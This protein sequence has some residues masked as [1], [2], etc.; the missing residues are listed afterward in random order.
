MSNK[1]KIFATCKAGCLW[2]TV[3]KADFVSS[4]ALVKQEVI[5]NGTCKEFTLYPG[6]TCILK[7][8]IIDPVSGYWWNVLLEIIDD[9]NN[10][11]KG[12]ES[13]IRQGWDT[14]IRV[15]HCGVFPVDGEEGN[16][17][18]Y[19]EINGLYGGKLQ[20]KF[21]GVV[22]EGAYIRLTNVDEVYLV[23]DG[24]EFISAETESV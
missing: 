3:H 1:P 11:R 14:S 22:S 9:N 21:N 24:F 15:K 23:N 4:A 19:Y 13:I 2:E 18:L 6:Q 10:V 17:I 20:Y 5:D 7:G 12:P 8:D 16:F